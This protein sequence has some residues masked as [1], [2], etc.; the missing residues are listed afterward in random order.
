MFHSLPAVEPKCVQDPHFSAPPDVPLKMDFVMEQIQ[1]QLLDG[2]QEMAVLVDTG[3]SMFRCG[4]V[5]SG[6][7]GCVC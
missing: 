2:S 6:W 7:S 4:G 1:T 3:D 5:F